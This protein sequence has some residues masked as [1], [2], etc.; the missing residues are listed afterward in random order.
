MCCGEISVGGAQSPLIRLWCDDGCRGELKGTIMF[1][2]LRLIMSCTSLHPTQVLTPLGHK[3]LTIH[4]YRR[5][6]FCQRQ[7]LSKIIC[8]ERSAVAKIRFL[9]NI[10]F[11]I[12]C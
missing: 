2:L 10:L 12:M 3:L 6:C 7:S 5:G 1:E 9:S 11:L 4:W 8:D